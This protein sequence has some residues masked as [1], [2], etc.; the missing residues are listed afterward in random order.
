LAE[1]YQHLDKGVD[2]MNADIVSLSASEIEAALHALCER[3]I[4]SVVRGRYLLTDLRADLESKLTGEEWMPRKLRKARKIARWLARLAGVRA[5]F[6]CNRTAFGLPHDEGDLDFFVIVRHGSI[7]Q[8]RG[9]AGLPFVLLRDRPKAGTKERD[10]VCLSFFLSD[11]ALDLAPCLL[12]PDDVYF[13]HWF[14]GLLPLV[15][16]GVMQEL[17]DANHKIHAQHLSA[18]VWIASPDLRVP[19]PRVRFPVNVWLERL[20]RALQMK[21]FPRLLRERAN[22]DTRVMISDQYLKFHIDDGREAVQERYQELCQRYGI[23]A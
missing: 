19:K 6:L 15:D 11:Q 16:D 3:K 21:Y 9:L 10:V 23:V 4:V 7:W 14:L 18:K 5:V 2:E 20:A 1:L 8:T 12:Q 17:W 22:Q 13:R